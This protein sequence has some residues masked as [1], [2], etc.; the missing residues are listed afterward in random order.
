MFICSKAKSA[1]KNKISTNKHILVQMNKKA[2]IG[3]IC[4]NV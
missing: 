2:L 4:T 3:I 1:G